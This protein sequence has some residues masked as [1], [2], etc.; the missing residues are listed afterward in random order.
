MQDRVRILRN[1]PGVVT[2]REAMLQGSTLLLTLIGLR[3][4]PSSSKEA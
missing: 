3:H 2:G 4:V 1:R